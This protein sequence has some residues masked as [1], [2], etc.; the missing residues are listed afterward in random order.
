MPDLPV[1]FTLAQLL[2]LSGTFLSTGSYITFVQARITKFRATR[3][4]DSWFILVNGSRYMVFQK[5]AYWI[6]VG[7]LALFV[8]NHF[9]GRYENDARCLASQS[10]AAVE[11][12][13]G[14]ATRVIAMTETMLDRGETHFAR[15]QIMVACAQTRLASLQTVIASH[16]A[17]LA[18]VQAEHARIEALQQVRGIVVCPR[19]N[20]RIAVPQLHREGTI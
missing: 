6:A 7:V 16:E 15:T 12:L 17:A 20:L 14:Q 1:G 10:L 11:Q 8:T 9:A 4:T 2:S 18:R 19:Q 3:L 5:A 13:S